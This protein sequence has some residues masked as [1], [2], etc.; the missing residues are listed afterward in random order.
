MVTFFFKWIP[1]V[2]CIQR[3]IFSS[4]LF[5]CYCCTTCMTDK[6]L[7]KKTKQIRPPKKKLRESKIIITIKE[8]TIVLFWVFFPGIAASHTN[9]SFGVDDPLMSDRFFSFS[10][11]DYSFL[12]YIFPLHDSL[13]TQF[14]K[15][16]KWC[17]QKACG[18]V[19]QTKPAL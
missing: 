5:Y 13:P 12:L 6:R 2:D 3:I 4:F 18:V 7:K 1:H 10:Q 17:C 9:R 16:I 15:G 14:L 8:D 11:Q 19:H